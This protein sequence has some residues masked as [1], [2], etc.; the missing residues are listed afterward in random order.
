[1]KRHN[2]YSLQR[3]VFPLPQQCQHRSAAAEGPRTLSQHVHTALEQAQTGSIRH[4]QP[5]DESPHAAWCKLKL[6]VQA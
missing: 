6:S 4:P 1:M 5:S 3:S 2:K